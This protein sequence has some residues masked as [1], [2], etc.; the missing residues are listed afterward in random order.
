M[1]M[2]DETSG[3]W[4]QLFCID[5]IIINRGVDGIYRDGVRK[6]AGLLLYVQMRAWSIA[7]DD[8]AALMHGV[9]AQPIGTA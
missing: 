1:V 6:A 3:R 8:R 2:N 4:P 7:D 9:V 5:E